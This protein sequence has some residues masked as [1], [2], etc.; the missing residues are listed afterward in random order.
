MTIIICKC[1]ESFLRNLQKMACMFEPYKNLSDFL[2]TKLSCISQ[3]NSWFLMIL[4]SCA[5]NKL[6]IQV[7]IPYHQDVY[8]FTICVS[9]DSCFI[10]YTIL[11]LV[12]SL[13]IYYFMFNRSRVSYEYI[14]ECHNTVRQ[15][16]NHYLFDP[17][18]IH[19][20]SICADCIIV[21]C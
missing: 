19:N 14:I 4:F 6:F 21:W 2:H 13:H 3:L 11:G 9:R 7:T 20:I 15:Y 16:I 1:F 18:N 17:N 12:C 5:D 8:E 10:T